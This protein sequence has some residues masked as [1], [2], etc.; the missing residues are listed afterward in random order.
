MGK[1]LYL[2]AILTF[3]VGN[4]AAETDP[5]QNIVRAM[6]ELKRTGSVCEPYLNGSPLQTMTG[7][8]AFFTALNQ[9][10]PS[11]RDKAAEARVGQLVKQHAAYIC[12]QKLLK[13]Q[14]QYIKA[15]KLYMAQKSANWPDAPSIIFPQWCRDAACSDY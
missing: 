8:D 9:P 11:P 5:V 4:A 6:V 10:V 3:C 15:A 1:L 7:I 14:N 2:S 12:S 13:A